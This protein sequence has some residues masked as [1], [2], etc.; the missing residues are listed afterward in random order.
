M[1][2][3]DVHQL[4][5]QLNQMENLPDTERVG[6]HNGKLVRAGQEG[7]PQTF[8]D[9]QNDLKQLL[10]QQVRPKDLTKY[11]ISLEQSSK[12]T[13]GTL[14]KCLEV[15]E[16]KQESVNSPE[17]ELAPTPPLSTENNALAVVPLPQ[18]VNTLWGTLIASLQAGVSSILSDIKYIF[19][20]Q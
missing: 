6:L 12:L 7:V 18:E 19:Q 13:A 10:K 17:S 4:S 15:I 9:C 20:S 5:L 16:K 2:G 1:I 3:I 14:R 8:R 11:R